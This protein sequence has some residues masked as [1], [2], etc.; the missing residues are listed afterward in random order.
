MT[1]EKY[2]KRRYF[3]AK[4][5]GAYSAL[6]GF[7]KNSKYQDKEKILSG[8][9]TY[10]VHRPVRKRF[11]RRSMICVTTDWLWQSDVLFYK[12]HKWH[13]KG[14][15]YILVCVDCFSKFLFC[16]PMKKKTAENVRDGL[17]K[18]FKDSKR[19]PSLLQTDRG[20]EYYSKPV[21]SLLEKQGIKLYSTHTTMKA[22]IAERYIRTIKTK[23]ER[24]M[25]HTGSKN[26]VSSLQLI[27]DNIN[28]SFNR[29]IGMAPNNVSKANEG[30]VFR[31]LYHR[32]I[33]KESKQPKYKVGDLVKITN[34]K[35]MFAKGY[36][37]NL[38]DATYKISQ[39]K[40]TVPV[41]VYILQ[42][43][44]GNLLE[45]TFYEEEIKKVSSET[46]T[47]G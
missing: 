32:L 11:K 21:K 26:W 3:S 46:N 28:G 8:L 30:E 31:N 7:M 47:D 18:I 19:K 13:N 14:F 16:Q 38:S 9:Y 40:S 22:M 24:L 35:L 17:S 23:I 33:S 39:I 10:N 4:Q 25:T 41:P 15:A 29:S 5:P 43:L 1:D 42:D 20:T 37:Q 34:I 2:V 44:E 36:E 12:K 6:S 27:V 45:G